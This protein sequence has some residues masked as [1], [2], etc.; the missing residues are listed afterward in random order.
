M[1][2]TRAYKSSGTEG[3]REREG[4]REGEL[5]RERVVSRMRIGSV[6]CDQQVRGW[7]GGREGGWVG[8]IYILYIHI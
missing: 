3:G 8:G 1:L 2:R 7:V 6:N 4:G 5:G